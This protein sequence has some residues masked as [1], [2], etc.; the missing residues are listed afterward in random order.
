MKL[1]QKH[2]DLLVQ[3]FTKGVNL[4]FKA[5]AV[6][7]AHVVLFL[8]GLFLGS[9]FCK[10]C[11]AR[12][13]Y[14][15]TETEP[16]TVVYGGPTLFRFTEQV[17]TISRASRFSISPSDKANPDYSILSVTPRFTKGSDRVTFLLANGAVVSTKIHIISKA[18]PEKTDSFYDFVPKKTLIESPNINGASVTDL[19]LMKAMIQWQEVIGYKVRSIV[20]PITTGNLYLSARLVR[21]YTGSKYNG[22]VFKVKNR[23]RKKSYTLDV[24][25]LSLGFPNQALLS[26]V[27]RKVLKPKVKGSKENVTFLRVVAKPS[28][29]YYNV[30]LPIG[31]IQS[32]K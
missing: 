11:D 26:Q 14:Y 28:S 10:K 19:E 5:L 32:S 6:F 31:P 13:I 20:F 12:E 16:I 25:K 8:V 23:S 3:S 21:I 1:T 29:I 22:Y 30:N 18:I 9:I 2:I 4:L 7:V 24:R 15:G 27:D 17:K